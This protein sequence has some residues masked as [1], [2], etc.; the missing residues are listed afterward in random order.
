[1]PK[2]KKTL[3]GKTQ[4]QRIEQ[5]QKLGS[6]KSLTVQPATRK[7]YDRAL[8][9]FFK[10]LKGENRT[11]PKQRRLLDDLVAIYLEALWEQGEGRALASDTLASLQDSD[12]KLKGMLPCSWRLMKVWVQHEIPAR[13]PP[14]PEQALQGLVGYAL[15]Q[16]D[17]MF[18]LSLLLGYYGMLRTGE[19]LSL[20]R[21]H[22]E[23]TSENGPAIISLGL[24]KSGRRQGA[25]ES[26]TITVHEVTRRLFQWKQSRITWLVPSAYQWRVKFNQYLEATGLKTFD[27][28]PYSLRRGGATF[29]F[30]RHG[31]F[32]RLLVQGRWSAI[33]TA[34][35][36]INSGLATLAELRMPKELR[37]FT[38]IYVKALNNHLPSLVK[39]VVQGDVEGAQRDKI[40]PFFPFFFSKFSGVLN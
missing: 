14:L 20:G 7:R 36:Y 9:L 21:H 38:S 30:T 18:A 40:E 35:I 13:A 19:V 10:F 27:F 26:V 25:E 22:V 33:K 11:L 37:G 31:S 1:M 17:A 3:E 34:K 12:P 8:D 6:L 24:T 15:L 39:R 5:R 16:G 23:I 2:K 28:R 29:W 32:D 4:Q